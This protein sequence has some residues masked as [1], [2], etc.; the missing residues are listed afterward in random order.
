MLLKDPYIAASLAALEQVEVALVGIG[1]L[2]PSKLLAASGNVFSAKELESLQKLGAV[3]DICLRFFDAQGRPVQSKL[4]E[5]VIGMSL[6]QLAKVQRTVGLAAGPRKVKAMRAALGA[7][8]VSV[9]VT[10]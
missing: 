6:P 2:E 1:D 5:R 3:G 8:L 4:D 10:D 7:G 9:L